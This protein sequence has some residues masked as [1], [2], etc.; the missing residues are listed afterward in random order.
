MHLPYTFCA[1]QSTTWKTFDNHFG[2]AFEMS[3]L[4]QPPF[5]LRLTVTINAKKQQLVLR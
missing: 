1:Y 4:P 2:A 3:N 5:N